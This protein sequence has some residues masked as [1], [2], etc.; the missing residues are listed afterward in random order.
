MK[1]SDWSW[2]LLEQFIQ[3][4]H[5]Q[6]N[7]NKLLLDLESFKV[8]NLFPNILI[9]KIKKIIHNLNVILNIHLLVNQ[10]AITEKLFS[11]RYQE[12]Y[13]GQ[14]YHYLH[15]KKFLSLKIWV[16][17]YKKQGQ[18]KMNNYFSVIIYW[19]VKWKTQYAE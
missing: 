14:S 17:S 13:W 5:I 16:R 7:L 3:N 19:C 1:I 18:E 4:S 9:S 12:N 10:G 11:W 2:K 8:K 6:L 15:R